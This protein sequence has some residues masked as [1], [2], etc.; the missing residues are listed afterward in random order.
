MR[1][2]TRGTNGVDFV[3]ITELYEKAVFGGYAPTDDEVERV[4]GYYRAF[5]KNAFKATMWPKWVFWR[6]WRL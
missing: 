5:Y 6:F 3:Q 1:P 2:Y 4:R